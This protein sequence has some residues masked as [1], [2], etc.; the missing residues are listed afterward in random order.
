[1][2]LFVVAQLIIGAGAAPFYSLL[3]AYLDENVKPKLIPVYLGIWFCFTFIA[4]GIGYL[5]GG[6]FLSFYVDIEQVCLTIYPSVMGVMV[7][8]VMMMVMMMMMMVVYCG[9][10]VIGNFNRFN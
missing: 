4:P 1:M 8:M 5:I 10:I 9:V 2:M 7:M 3:P 6:Y